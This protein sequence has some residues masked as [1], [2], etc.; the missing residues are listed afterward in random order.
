MLARLYPYS[1]LKGRSVIT[2]F[3]CAGCENSPWS[4]LSCQLSMPWVVSSPYEEVYISEQ[5]RR[6]R[7]AEQVR[8]T[9]TIEET[10]TIELNPQ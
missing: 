1:L 10:P 9:Q 8:T 7:S 3:L 5:L 2:V 4:S 6:G